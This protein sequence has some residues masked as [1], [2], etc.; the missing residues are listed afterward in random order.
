M[1]ARIF[2]GCPGVTLSAGL[3]ISQKSSFIFIGFLRLSW[4]NALSQVFDFS[5]A[6]LFSFSACTGTLASGEA[7]SSPGI[8][9][10]HP[11]VAVFWPRR[12]QFLSRRYR[13][14]PGS[15]GFARFLGLDRLQ[16]KA[17]AMPDDDS[18]SQPNLHLV[19]GP[20]S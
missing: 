16:R 14:G 5:F 1:G 18:Q 19:A 9:R 2:L 12:R 8:V 13:L 3:A 15:L 4:V 20:P 17:M 7:L 10:N 6:V 11:S